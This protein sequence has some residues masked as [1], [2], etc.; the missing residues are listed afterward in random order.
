M[1]QDF[2]S[3]ARALAQG[4]PG[5]SI[6]PYLGPVT[7][8]G[9][10]FF[11]LN[12]NANYGDADLPVT[13]PLTME[14]WFWLQKSSN[15]QQAFFEMSNG[16]IDIGI[17]LSAALQPHCFG[18]GGQ[19]TGATAITRQNWHHIVMTATLAT[20]TLYSDGVSVGT[21][22]GAAIPFSPTLVVG[23]GGTASSPTRFA[24]AAIS[25][26]AFYSTALSAGRVAAHFAAVDNIASRPVWHANGTF[27]IT[28][29]GG[30][31]SDSTTLTQIAT[32][33]DRTFS[34]AP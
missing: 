7:D 19:I 11:D 28:G 21:A 33:V 25:E 23:S 31:S 1:L 4:I 3:A 16:T 12:G 29:G 2:G 22:A 20:V 6:L 17:G 18:P 24:H 15:A 8:G 9:S 14:C 26:V 13:L 30:A 5:Q 32:G 34:N 27:D 10:A